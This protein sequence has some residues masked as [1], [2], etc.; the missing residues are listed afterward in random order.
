MKPIIARRLKAARE[1]KGLTQQE[2]S[3]ELGFKDRQTLAA[4]EAGLRKVSAEELVK[5][6]KILGRDLDY[7]TD[8]L[9]IEGEGRFSWRADAES[10][11]DVADLESLAGGWIAMY[12]SFANGA[13]G[14]PA[15]SA[16]LHLDLTAKSSLEDA[17]HAAAWL[18]DE[19]N[20]GETP[21]TTLET[22]IKQKLRVLVLHVDTAYGIDSAAVRLP[23]F[24]AILLS[25]TAPA[26]KRNFNLAHELFH[27]LTWETM[28]PRH[29]EHA[30]LDARSKPEQLANAFALVLLMPEPAVRATFAA[31]PAGANETWPRS[32]ADST[33]T[34]TPRWLN[35]RA[36]EFQVTT[37]AYQWR[38][39]QLAML[40]K[41]RVDKNIDWTHK[42]KPSRKRQSS[43]SQA[44]AAEANF[45]STPVLASR[46]AAENPASDV[47]DAM[48]PS[49]SG[50][51]T[52]PRPFSEE[53]VH[54]LHAALK[55]KQLELDRA[56]QLL[57]LDEDEVAD[58]FRTYQLE[59]PF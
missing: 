25:R 49:P 43:E 27:L 15:R 45:M 26:P 3:D 13:P 41:N 19:W 55:D 53:F 20:L 29:T 14:V 21:A 28:A 6:I 12:R 58:L 17:Q 18:G 40:S 16:P 5:I 42:R 57:G 23:G 47:A 46:A 2:L 31:K 4:M 38:L 22:A 44:L 48:L 33:Q 24:N 7:F 35:D 30:R 54:V 59:V 8:P 1:A 51:V 37:E 32:D 39:V 56:V 34:L 36:R 9:R 11:E 50:S 52:D 10:M